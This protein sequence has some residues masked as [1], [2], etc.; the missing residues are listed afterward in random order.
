MQWHSSVSLSLVAWFDERKSAFNLSDCTNVRKG[1]SVPEWH[2]Q[3]WPV[4]VIAKHD[5]CRTV[6]R[7]VLQVALCPGGNADF[8]INGRHSH[9]FSV[10]FE[11]LSESTKQS[12]TEGFNNAL[13]VRDMNDVK[14]MESRFAILVPRDL[15]SNL[16]EWSTVFTGVRYVYDF[17]VKSKGTQKTMMFFP[18]IE[19]VAIAIILQR[20]PTW[21]QP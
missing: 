6:S 15:K 2:I 5:Q 4:H 19:A 7:V 14:I 9:D 8:K 16:V 11:E 1:C 13:A 17:V 12:F 18:E 3:Q 20:E 21:Q 10:L